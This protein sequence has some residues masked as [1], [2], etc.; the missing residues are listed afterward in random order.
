MRG[1]PIGVYRYYLQ[2]VC[3]V[4]CHSTQPARIR[5]RRHSIISKSSSQSAKQST[6]KWAHAVSQFHTLS[7]TFR[8]FHPP[9]GYEEVEIG[10]LGGEVGVGCR[11][12]ECR[13]TDNE[14]RNSKYHGKQKRATELRGRRSVTNRFATAD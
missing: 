1:S 8:F 3:I 14:T 2:I 5:R 12:Q 13:P 6:T 7:F 4:M 10:C 9:T 11:R